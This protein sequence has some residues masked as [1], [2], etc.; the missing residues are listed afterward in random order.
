MLDGMGYETGVNL[1]ALL[2]IAAELPGLVGHE[3]PGQVL[4]A[5]CSTR[6]YP[7]PIEPERVSLQEPWIFE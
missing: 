3:V 7:V 5:G 2:L 1:D 6:R 4:K